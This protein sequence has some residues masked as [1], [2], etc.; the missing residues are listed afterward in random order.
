MLKN[1]MSPF[2]QPVH[3][4]F[5]PFSSFLVLLF[6]KFSFNN[7]F[8]SPAIRPAVVGSTGDS[9]YNSTGRLPNCC[10]TGATA[11]CPT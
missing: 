4:L 2:T 10:G 6:S 5:L 8:N 7:I 3:N 9:R 1:T 11:D